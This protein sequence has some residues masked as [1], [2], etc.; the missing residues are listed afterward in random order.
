MKPE[1]A[2]RDSERDWQ[3][4]RQ[5]GPRALKSRWLHACNQRCGDRLWVARTTDGGMHG[6]QD[7]A[8]VPGAAKHW[9]ALHRREPARRHTLRASWSSASRTTSRT[10]TAARPCSRWLVRRDIVVRERHTGG[11]RRDSAPEF[12]TQGR[13]R[14]MPGSDRWVGG[15]GV[16]GPCLLHWQARGHPLPRLGLNPQP[17]LHSRDL[18]RQHSYAD[19]RGRETDEK[20]QSGRRQ[21][22]SGGGHWGPAFRVTG[23]T[24]PPG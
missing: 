1:V 4:G 23:R 10:V 17:S 19:R 13:C 3:A 14:G 24:V 22:L 12:P 9:H 15:D 8:R 2:G 7:G 11:L 18:H 16:S 20:R 6:C 21:W 5:Q